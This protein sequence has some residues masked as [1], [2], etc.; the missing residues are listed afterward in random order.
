MDKNTQDSILEHIDGQELAE[1]TKDL[2]DILSPTGA[3]KEIG[4][5]ILNWYAEN[6]LKPIRQEIDPNRVNAVGILQG[7]GGGVS[8]MINGHMDTSFT[9][10]EDDL[11]LCRELEPQSEL[12]G[13][14]FKT[15]LCSS[16]G[17]CSRVTPQAAWGLP[18]VLILTC[19]TPAW[20]QMIDR[21][22]RSA[23]MA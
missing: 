11:M 3:E 16:G 7:T 20:A 2:V 22:D 1:L 8:L 23:T 13:A 21:A 9:G 15:A 4:E 6:G 14:I 12:Q 18:K 5:F 10:G 17:S 19:A